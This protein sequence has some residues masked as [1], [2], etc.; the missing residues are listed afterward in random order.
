METPSDYGDFLLSL[1]FWSLLARICWNTSLRHR[2]IERVHPA[3][4][5][6]AD[7]TEKSSSFRHKCVWWV[8]WKR[9][10]RT[11]AL[12]IW[13]HDFSSY[14]FGPS[15]NWCLPFKFSSSLEL[16]HS[17]LDTAPACISH[18]NL[19][20]FFDIT[21]NLSQSGE[22]AQKGRSFREIQHQ[23]R[24]NMHIRIRNTSFRIT[25][26]H[27]TG[28][29]RGW[30]AHSSLPCL[31]F[32]YTSD[33]MEETRKSTEPHSSYG[34]RLYVSNKTLRGKCN[35]MKTLKK[36]EKKKKLVPTRPLRAALWRFP[37]SD[38][39]CASSASTVQ[40]AVVTN[41]WSFL[42][43]HTHTHTVAAVHPL[44]FPL[45]LRLLGPNSE[46]YA[47]SDQML[48]IVFSLKSNLLQRNIYRSKNTAN[49]L[50][51]FS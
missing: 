43:W 18:S 38:T 47:V 45:Y 2:F 26:R 42:L 51:A 17:S 11:E 30:R 33:E 39:S 21:A 31:S 5:L 16:S 24:R 44:W 41:R 36:K 50:V 32:L 8:W 40:P 46:H 19:S 34:A 7:W 49:L 22:T 13:C 4:I 1:L 48:S 25:R 12:L 23:G 37:S 9:Q 20:V 29:K 10:N 35:T 14:A 27:F 28:W 3:P 6:F 15:M